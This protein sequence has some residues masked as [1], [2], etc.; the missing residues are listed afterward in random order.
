MRNVVY[1]NQI[2]FQVQVIKITEGKIQQ[3]ILFFPCEIR[4]P[5]TVFKL[6]TIDL[7]LLIYFGTLVELLLY[8]SYDSNEAALR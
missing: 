3:L 2:L 6:I 4:I 1:V 7:L 5:N 8:S